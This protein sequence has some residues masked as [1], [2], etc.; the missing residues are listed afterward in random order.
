[1]AC[2][3]KVSALIEVVSRPCPF[4]PYTLTTCT[5]SSK[6]KVCPLE[7]QRL[8]VL[9]QPLEGL[10]ALVVLHG[11]LDFR[12]ECILR[13][14]DRKSSTEGEVC[15]NAVVVLDATGLN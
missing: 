5:I 3:F 12:C 13:K 10:I 6:R 7:T 1:M 11:E 2:I 8:A 15:D 4:R 14:Y 9:R